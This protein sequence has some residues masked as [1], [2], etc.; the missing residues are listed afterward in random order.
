MRHVVDDRWDDQL[1]PR[2]PIPGRTMGCTGLRTIIRRLSHPYTLGRTDFATFGK[3]ESTIWLRIFIENQNLLKMMEKLQKL[4][5][6]SF[7][8]R[9]SDARHLSLFAVCQSLINIYV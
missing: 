3:V 7:T 2:G 4:T 1:K 5:N 8:V 6:L 9:S